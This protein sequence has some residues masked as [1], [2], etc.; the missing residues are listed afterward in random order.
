MSHATSSAGLFWHLLSRLGEAQILLPAAFVFA[1]WLARRAAGRPLVRWWLSLV[2][3]ATL[4]TTASKLAFIGWGIGSAT[5]N[6]TGVSGHAMFAA[7]IYPLLAATLASSRAPRW[8]GLALVGGGAFALLIG[9]SRVI[10][11]AHSPSEVIAGLVLGAA[12][13]A[14]ALV[15]THTPS[16][17][18]PLL[19]PFALALWLAV[20]PASAPPSNTHGM[21]TASRSHCPAAANPTPAARCC[22]PT[23][24]GKR[25][26]R[27]RGAIRRPRRADESGSSSP[28]AR[29]AVARGG[30]P[31]LARR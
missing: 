6:F 3:V 19:M 5:L 2:V 20:T 24:T 27:T 1:W 14:A 26:S 28:A 8:Q 30:G 31:K 22:A 25:S 21:V 10:V 29:R 16:T 15:L 13:S 7:A 18:T 12:A 23:S 11:G 4:I 17:R 9:V